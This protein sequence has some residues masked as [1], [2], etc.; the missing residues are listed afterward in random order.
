MTALT[1]AQQKFVDELVSSGCTPTEAARRSGFSAPAQ[2][3]YRLMRKDHVV[4]AIR[5]LRE[6]MIS[7]HAA[8]VAINTLVEIMTDKTAP[9]SARVSAAR[10][11]CEAAGDFDR[12]SRIGQERAMG[13]MTADEL[14]QFIG[15]LDLAVEQKAGALH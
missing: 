1:D 13:D 10:T 3:A 11:V 9:A 14:I 4:L 7:G 8:N 2:E 12:A 15:R 5:T 6:R